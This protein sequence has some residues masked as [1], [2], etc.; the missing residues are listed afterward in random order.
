MIA[1]TMNYYTLND[2]DEL[3]ERLS[4]DKYEF[5]RLTSV[6]FCEIYL[7]LRTGACVL[8]RLLE[9]FKISQPLKEMEKF[10]R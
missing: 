9:F 2:R 3:A 5:T 10:V 1:L 8:S 4:S 6:D 7:T